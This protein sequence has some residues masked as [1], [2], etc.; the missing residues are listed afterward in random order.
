MISVGSYCIGSDLQMAVLLNRFRAIVIG[1]LGIAQ[2]LLQP[3]ILPASDAASNEAHS[4]YAS[5]PDGPPALD[6]APYCGIRCVHIAASSLGQAA[7]FRSLLSPEFVGSQGSS[8]QQL[9]DAAKFVGIVGRPASNLTYLSLQMAEGPVILHVKPKVTAESYS[10]WILLCSWN[11]ADCYVIDPADPAPVKLT[12]G[13]L[14]AI[15]D[16]NAILL[17]KDKAPALLPLRLTG[18]LQGTCCVLLAF[19]ISGAVRAAYEYLFEY[20]RRLGR[21]SGRIRVA[22]EAAMLVA[23]AVASAAC[24]ASSPW[25]GLCDDQEVVAKLVEYHVPDFLRAVSLAEMENIVDRADGTI[26]VDSRWKSDFDQ[27]AIAGAINIEPNTKTEECAK[28]IADVPTEWPIVVYCNMPECPY[29]REI[30]RRL[31]QA[32]YRN[33]RIFHGGWKKWASRHSANARRA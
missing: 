28:Q 32:G 18:I 31:L 30:S 10:H 9:L 7:S 1:S 11:E 23:V 2:Q 12:A 20:S 5:L 26:I 24:A 27:G 33:V 22:L 13:K 17:S 4:F 14:R 6:Y 3:S 21:A 8:G 29:S 16:G 19:V 25:I 15:W